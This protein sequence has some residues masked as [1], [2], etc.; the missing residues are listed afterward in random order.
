MKLAF[1]HLTVRI[2][3]RT[4]VADATGLA[5]PG[6]ITAL[7]GPNGAGKSTLLKALAGLLPCDGQ[8]ALGSEPRDRIARRDQIAYMPQD[9]SASSALSVLEV[10]LLGRYRSL[11]LTV[12]QD[13]VDDAMA[14][15]DR[16]GLCPLHTRTLDTLSGGQRQ[17]VYLAQTLFRDPAALLL[18]EPIAALDLRHQLVVLER[19]SRYSAEHGIAV[20]MAL[21]DLSLA[22]Q[23][24]SHVICV[25]DG[26]IVAGGPPDAVFDADLLRRVYGVETEIGMTGTGKLRITALA[27]VDL[28]AG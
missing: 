3:S 10:I 23:F 4:I 15:L 9:T 11:G 12:R 20:I 21:H 19:V 6:T 14:I 27:A 5:E 13:L 18:D 26:K 17:L 22:A 7:I 28:P 16:F 2:A 1:E 25:E 24:A 8:V